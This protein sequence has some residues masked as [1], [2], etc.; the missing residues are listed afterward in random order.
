M[1]LPDRREREK[2]KNGRK[3]GREKKKIGDDR[4]K[5]ASDKILRGGKKNGIRN[6]IQYFGLNK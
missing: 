2:R 3:K 4:K 1:K 6:A 5:H